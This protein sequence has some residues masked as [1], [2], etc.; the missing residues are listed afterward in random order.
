MAELSK[1]EQNILANV[2]EHGFFSTTV[3]DPDGKN[4]MFTYSTGF[5]ESLDCPDFI[6]VGLTKEIMHNMLWEIFHQI[7]KGAI[8]QDGMAWKGLLAGDYFCISKT[9]HP[10][11]NTTDYFN[12]ARWWYRHTGRQNADLRFYQMFWPGSQDKRF[13]WEEGCAQD[14]IDVQPMLYEKMPSPE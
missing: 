3:F 2:D 9:V 4:P 8:P 11:N 10:D 12:S 6:I 5:P 7:K 13:P 1:Y 14:V